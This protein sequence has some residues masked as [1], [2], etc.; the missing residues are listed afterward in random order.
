MPQSGWFKQQ[1][2]TFSQSWRLGVQGQSIGIQG[3]GIGRCGFSL[4]LSPWPVDGRFLPGSS[5]SLPFV[6]VFWFLLIRNQS[7]W[8]RAHPNDLILTQWTLLQMQLLSEIRR[9][10]A[11]TYGGRHNSVRNTEFSVNLFFLK[12]FS[13]IKLLPLIIS[14]LVQ[15]S[16]FFCLLK[17]IILGRVL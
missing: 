7:H 4:G 10:R 2:G 15:S 9:V 12:L 13:E 3:Q 5:H 8:I 11:S 16:V 14:Q 1:K 6:S 17:N